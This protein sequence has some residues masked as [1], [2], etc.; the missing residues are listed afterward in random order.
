MKYGKIAVSLLAAVSFACAWGGDAATADAWQKKPPKVETDWAHSRIYEPLGWRVSVPYGFDNRL[1]TEMPMGADGTFFVVSEKASIEAARKKG[2]DIEGVGWIFSLGM[3]SEA[4]LHEILCGDMSGAELF[5]K[6]NS[7]NYFIYYHPT[8]VRYVRSDAWRMEKD[9]EKWS[10]LNAWAWT[11]VRESFVGL[12]SGI[13]KLTADNSDVGICIAKTMYESGTEYTISQ[14]GKKTAPAKSFSAVPY[15]EKLLYGVSY[16]MLRK[17]TFPN[18]GYVSLD[19]PKEG[20]RLDFYTDGSGRTFVR[21]VRQGSKDLVYEA[22][23][24]DESIRPMAVLSSWQG[25]MQGK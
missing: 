9:Q 14:N 12:N 6:D 21:E 18:D 19:L 17:K 20:I 1:V 22:V 4:R 3:V 23:F 11:D 2:H 15:G 25:A 24:E 7:G 13:T 16:E 10:E 8:D 5:A